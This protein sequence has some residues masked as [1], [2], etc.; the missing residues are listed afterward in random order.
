LDGSLP[1][2][3]HFVK[4]DEAEEWKKERRWIAIA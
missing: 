2:P 1:P 4:I 3:G